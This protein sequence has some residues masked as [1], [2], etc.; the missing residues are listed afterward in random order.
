MTGRQLEIVEEVFKKRMIRICPLFK[1][2]ISK[3]LEKAG[4]EEIPEEFLRDLVNKYIDV[5]SRSMF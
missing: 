4:E 5:R 2:E 1:M 3:A